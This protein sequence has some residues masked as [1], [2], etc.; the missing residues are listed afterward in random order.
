MPSRVTEIAADIYRIS[1]FHA[2]YGIQF[3]QFLVRDEE[4]F[5]MHTGFRRMFDTT[6]EAVRTASAAARIGS[7]GGSNSSAS[8]RRNASRSALGSP[9]NS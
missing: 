3:N 9:R 5:L 4:P 8:T 1:T 6:L 2:D 7:A